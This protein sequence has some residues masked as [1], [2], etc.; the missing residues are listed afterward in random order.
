MKTEKDQKKSEPAEKIQDY[1]RASYA[2]KRK[3]VDLVS[4]G[5]IS[6]NAAAKKYN[7]SRSSLD[8]WMKKMSTLE[9]KETTMS[10]DKELKKLRQRIEE[11]EF[12]KDFQQ[13]LIVEY[14]IETG[15]LKSKKYLPEQLAK[16]IEQKRK[17]AQ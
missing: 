11:L 15:D 9:Q 12:I 8:Y 17:K 14:E 7:V 1:V 10:K 13:D 4:N 3:I 6:K 16:E 2:L 5:R